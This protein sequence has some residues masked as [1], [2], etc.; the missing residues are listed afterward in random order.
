MKI[1]LV[2]DD[3]VLIKV[4]SKNL[5]THHYIVDV[6]K[7]GEMGWTYG[8]TFEYDLIILDIMLPKLDG[9]SLCKR[10]R[11]QGYTV[12]ILLLTAQD[13]ITAKVQ[14]LDAGADDY[15]V[16]PFDPIELI[17]RIRALLRRGSNNPFPLLT[18]GDLLLNPSTCEVTYNGRSLNLTT[19]EYDLL[20]LL[21]RNCQHVFSSEELLDKLWSSEDFPSEATVR[22]HIRRLRHKL[23]TAGAPHDFIATMHGRGY[24]LKAPSTEEANDLSATP[25]N[26]SHSAAVIAKSKETESDRPQHLI[27][28]DSQQQYL[29]FLNET[30]TRTKP[31][32]L[33]QMGI[34]LQIIRDLQ[35]NQL[36]PQQ[37]TQAQQVAHKL[38]GTLGIFGLT[39]TMHIARQL[40]YWLGGRERLQPKHAPLMKT[41]VTALQQDIDHTTLIQMSQIPAG[42]SPLLLIISP[43]NEFNQSIVAV[44]ASRGIRIQIAPAPDVAQ[45]M[46]TN[47]SVLDAFGE[48]PDVILM[49]LPSIP[50]RAEVID[51]PNSELSNFWETLQTFAERYPKLPIVVIGDRGEMSDRLEAM[52]RGGKLFL[53]TPTPPEQ[54]VDTVVNLLRDPEIPN[55]IMILDDD[56]DWLRTLP[57][58]LKPWGFKVTTLADPQQFWAVLQAVTPDALVLDVNMPQI[59]GFELCQILRS[60]PHW[61]RLP[62]LFLSVLTDPTTQNQ[63]FAVGGDDYLCKPVKGVELANRILRRLQRVRAWAN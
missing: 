60:D 43:D 19:M 42:Q 45:A 39:K 51:Q 50:S 17:A 15:V 28:S 14:G 58:L 16:K 4:L 46:L 49:R 52:R 20:E 57:T 8:S 47:E 21:L 44:A 27:P 63:A 41:L 3:D 55:K 25:E 37:Q 5:T 56:Q 1:L 32:S 31:Q 29:A 53:V 24:Y 38:A 62:V 18:W 11:A 34:L 61:Q 59:N 54:I 9:I 2:E 36:T 48:D 12:P 13:N 40:E 23:V 30:W 35:T 26:N 22:S 33:D 7:D 6:V 10:F